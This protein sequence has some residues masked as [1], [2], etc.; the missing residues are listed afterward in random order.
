[1]K[2]E[3][4]LFV[5]P[6]SIVRRIWGDADVILLIFAGSAAEFALNRE[7]D[8]LF[9]TG[10][11]PADPI[12][13]LFSTVRYAQE[14]VFQ[15]E[16]KA[17]KAVGRMHAIHG[18]VEQSRGRQ[19]PPHAYRDVLYMLID[20]SIR[21]FERLHRPLTTAEKEEVFVTFRRV[22]AGMH[23]PDLPQTLADWLTDRQKHLEADLERSP[24]TD[25][26]F[27]RYREELGDWRYN[28]LLQAQALLVPDKVRTL[29]NLPDKPLLASTMWLYG[30][31]NALQL[32]AVV[33][34]VLLPPKYLAQVQA[35]DR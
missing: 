26:L 2:T 16:Q 4:T 19:I 30:V 14:I 21:A 9:F 31:L 33:Q 23:I 35:L 12:G 5:Q 24:F 32:R 22:G 7:V 8:W 13:R 3:T 17:G 25:K 29:L 18:V 28:L 34:R 10:K 1:M 27:V 15:D 20:Y 6:D 11:L